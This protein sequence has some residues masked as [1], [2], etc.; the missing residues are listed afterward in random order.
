MR[1]FKYQLTFS[2][3]KKQFFVE[4]LVTEFAMKALNVAVLPRAARSDAHWCR[5]SLPE[6]VRYA[7]GG[8]Q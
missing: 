7:P 1:L 3:T 8:K 4:A 6:R 5:T 2:P